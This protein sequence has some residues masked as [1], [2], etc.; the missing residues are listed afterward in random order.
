MHSNP[1]YK[2]TIYPEWGQADKLY[3]TEKS[4]MDYAGFA[5]S[6]GADVS[7]KV[8]SG[9]KIINEFKIIFRS[10]VPVLERL[11]MDTTLSI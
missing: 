9:N 11:Q 5:A 1:W 10:S 4:G 3:F 7:G 8:F 6:W 2:D